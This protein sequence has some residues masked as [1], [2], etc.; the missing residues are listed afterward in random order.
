[1]KPLKCLEVIFRHTT[2]VPV[3]LSDG[4]LSAWKSLLGRHSKPFKA[5]SV[6]QSDS[7]TRSVS[8]TEGELGYDIPLEGLFASLLVRIL[9]SR[10]RN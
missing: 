8:R 10:F 3:R 5:F 6:V 4:H 9:G 7:K 1:V 2:T